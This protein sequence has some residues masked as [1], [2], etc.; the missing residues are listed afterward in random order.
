MNDQSTVIKNSRVIQ[1]VDLYCK[2]LHFVIGIA[3]KSTSAHDLKTR[4]TYFLDFL[5]H[6]I[7][8]HLCYHQLK[9]TLLYVLSSQVRQTVKKNNKQERIRNQ[10]SALSP[11]N[12]RIEIESIKLTIQLDTDTKNQTNFKKSIRKQ[13]PNT[14][15]IKSWVN[16]DAVFV[17][18]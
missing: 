10:I 2:S 7:S 8:S 16:R 17:A 1:S 14:Q 13:T 9:T 18:V 6:L 15:I 11:Q 5:S 3:Q 12:N 4:K